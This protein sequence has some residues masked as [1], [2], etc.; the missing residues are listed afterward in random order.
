MEDPQQPMHCEQTPQMAFL[1]KLHKKGGKEATA[2][3][4]A[5][6]AEFFERLDTDYQIVFTI[7]NIGMADPNEENDAGETCF[8]LAKT[9]APVIMAALKAQEERLQIIADGG[10]DPNAEEEKKKVPR[11]VE[12]GDT[13]NATLHNAVEGSKEGQ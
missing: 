10:D 1:K 11:L 12:F 9:K 3:I 8:D 13:W 5:S 4:M 2:A 7:C 6:V